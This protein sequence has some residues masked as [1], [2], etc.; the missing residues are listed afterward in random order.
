M[1]ISTLTI[2]ILSLSL[3][4]VIGWITYSVS[5]IKATSNVISP[6]DEKYTR[7]LQPNFN[8]KVL[9]NLKSQSN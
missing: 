9:E 8:S 3:V 2:V 1:K 6:V 4:T 7:P 5:R